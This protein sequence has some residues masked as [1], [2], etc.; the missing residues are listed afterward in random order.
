TA[1]LRISASGS[2]RDPRGALNVELAGA[3]GPRF[4]PTDARLDAS[5]GERD[6]RVALRVVR[7]ARELLSASGVLGVGAH[8]LRDLAALPAAPVTVTAALGPIHLHRDA[9]PG[10]FDA[11]G[12]APLS[13]EARA[14]LSVTG[15]L[16]RPRI[17]VDA[18]LGDARLGT[19]PL[20]EA[21]LLATY[22]DRRAD[23][24]LVLRGPATAGQL[25]LTN[26]TIVDLGYPA[27]MRGG[28][29]DLDRVGLD[30][31]LTADRFDLTWLS[32]ITD[33]VRRVGGQLSATI[34][35]KG[36]VRAPRVNGQLE[37]SEGAVG[38]RGL[39]DYEHVH[40]KAHGSEEA[41]VI[42]ELKLA[43]GEGEGRLTAQV[44]RGGGS[45]GGKE[46]G[47]AGQAQ[48]SLKRFPIYGQGQ[49]LALVSVDGSAKG[50]GTAA[51]VNATLTLS[52]AHVELTDAKQKDL[53]P[54]QRPADVVLLDGGQPLDRKE[55]RKLSAVADV[56]SGGADAGAPEG[57]S[58][59]PDKAS[60][61]PLEAHVAVHAPRN[62]WVRGKD[63]SLELGLGS[64]FRVDAG[65]A[66][67][68]RIYGRV[69]VRRGRL[70]VLGRRFDLQA[71][72]QVQF[73]GPADAPRLDVT[74]KHFNE[75]E[76]VS[77]L[78]TV[79][80]TLDKVSVEVSSPERPDL[81]E[82]QLYALIVTGRL[83]FGGNQAGSA[84]MSGQAASLVGGLVAAQLQKALAKRL[85]LDVLT[86]QAGEGLTGSRLEAG[87][88]LTTKLYAGYVGRVG[89][90]PALLQNRNAVHL[91]Y[92]LSRR[93]SF[94]GE[95]GDVGTGTADLVW[96]KHY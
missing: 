22:A 52:E 48:V 96:T 7:N 55:A 28:G 85:P 37:W 61:T 59:P 8:R 53:M 11:G 88:Y 92:Q 78:L 60:V 38:L 70:D 15:T 64:G 74:A 47:L 87:T 91:E 79:R 42:D 49:V 93:W 6:T 31:R 39:G 76:N 94:D 40:L 16:E 27:L 1:A 54:L 75:T 5:F 17:R 66:G 30:A 51:V 34:A 9:I 81:T 32:G 29:L 57:V 18:T 95:Y 2:A 25:H 80:G 35:A 21:R 56:L 50:D 89:A 10:A 44:R 67:P 68:P 90:N 20:G 63:A 73:V 82:G 3:A 65:G 14:R 36:S 62:L 71:G 58:P 45:R 77:V 41:L 26:R 33:Q 12:S 4:P 19:R 86:L 72:S 46:G 69:L 13:T 83:Q 23:A 84:G 24:D 43:S